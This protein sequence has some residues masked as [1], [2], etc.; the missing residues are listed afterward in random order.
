MAEIAKC[1]TCQSRGGGRVGCQWTS[2]AS[3]ARPSNCWSWWQ[4]NNSCTNDGDFGPFDKYDT[5]DTSDEIASKSK[6]NNTWGCGSYGRMCEQGFVWND[7]DCECQPDEN[8]PFAR[9]TVPDETREPLT[10]KAIK[11]CYTCEMGMGMGGG[12]KCVYSSTYNGNTPP[13]S[14]WSWY[15]CSQQHCYEAPIPD[16]FGRM[17]NPNQTGTNNSQNRSN[18]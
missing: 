17:S 15:Q 9:M 10:G 7:F 6:I 4:C 2:T 1:Y 3:G 18:Y 13:S 12:P 11:K 8:G 14:C 5:G 16:S